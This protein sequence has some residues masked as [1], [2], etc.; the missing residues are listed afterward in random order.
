MTFGPPNPLSSNLAAD[1]DLPSTPEGIRQ[2]MLIRERQTAS[3]VNVKENAQYE[4]FELITNVQYF[5]TGTTQGS[6]TT[7]SRLPRPG[8]RK[9]IDFGA[10]PNN[11]LKS[12]AHGLTLDDGVNPSTW[13][14]TK[15]Y[16]TAFDPTV[17]AELIISL[18]YYDIAAG[19][20][21]NPIAI[22][23]DQTNVKITT[24][25]NRTNF[26]RCYVILEYLKVF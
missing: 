9:V 22:S 20:V 16:A 2:F 8:F 23:A 14:F 18:P 1:F 19:A 24:T 25:S 26:T 7:A 12:V 17:G 13:F 6:S 15:I 11:A 10:L 21:A 3:I 5:N 4:K